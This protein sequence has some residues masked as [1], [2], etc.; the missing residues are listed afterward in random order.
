MF[1][2]ILAD[3]ARHIQPLATTISLLCAYG[4]TLY[5]TVFNVHVSYSYVSYAIKYLAYMSNLVGISLWDIFNNNVL[6]QRCSWLC[7]GIYLQKCWVF[8]PMQHVCNVSYI[9]NVTVNFFSVI[10][11]IYVYSA[12]C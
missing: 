11:V 5:R 7:F 2:C 12:P 6:S 8:L 1:L 9:G 4:T 10:C 3:L